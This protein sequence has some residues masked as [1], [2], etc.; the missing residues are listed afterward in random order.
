MVAAV[1]AVGLVERSR[2]CSDGR[3][4]TV[5]IT[6]AG[7]QLLETS[8]RWQQKMFDELTGGWSDRDRRRFA[9]YLARLAAEVGA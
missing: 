8:R 9:G 2:S 3:R 1:E 7:L 6:G 5:R 4:S